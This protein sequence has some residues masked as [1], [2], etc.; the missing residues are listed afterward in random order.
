MGGASKLY[1]S[2][3][4]FIEYKFNGIRF[5]SETFI[6]SS[7]SIRLGC[8]FALRPLAPCAETGQLVFDPHLDS[9]G[10]QPNRPLLEL[11]EHHSSIS[12]EILP[13]EVLEVIFRHLDGFSLN[14][15]SRTCKFFRQ[16]CFGLLEDKG[17]VL[18]VWKKISKGRSNFGSLKKR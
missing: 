5:K 11:H 12:L 14:N 3:L 13:P 4:R 18:P 8:A 6:M 17:M 10:V 15:V 2:L 7:L 9:F 1:T 16:V